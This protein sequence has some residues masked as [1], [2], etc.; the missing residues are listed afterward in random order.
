MVTSGGAGRDLAA[1]D[2]RDPDA[3]ED[4]VEGQCATR[5]PPPTITTC[6][7]GERAMAVMAVSDPAL[8]DP[9]PWLLLL[10]YSTQ[11]KVRVTAFFQSL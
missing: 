11:S 8:R 3:P 6:G 2:E 5:A 10:D 9:D 7:A 4:Q 1:F